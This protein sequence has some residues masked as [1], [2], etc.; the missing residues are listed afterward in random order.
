MRFTQLLAYVVLIAACG[1]ATPPP[2]PPPPADLA[3]TGVTLIDGGVAREGVTVL[4]DGEKI[5]AV[6]AAAELV[7]PA[8][9]RVVDG[10]GRFLIPGLWDVHVHLVNEPPI[11]PER[12]LALLLAH[13][14]VGVRDMGS[15]W[16][17]IE[18]LRARLAAG[19]IAGP[20]IV[21]PG[22]FVDGPQ[23]A[24][25]TVM[26]VAGAGE[27]RAAVRELR[28][29]GVDFIKAQANLPREAYQAL[30]DEAGQLGAEVHG[31]VP[32][33]LSALEVAAAGQVTIEHVSPS[34]PS[35]GALFFSCSA[36]ED[37][38]RLELA[39]IAAARAA[40]GAGRGQIAERDRAL[41]RAL[42]ES[43]DAEK[44]AALFAGLRDRGTRVV[45]TLVWSSTYSPYQAELPPDL[46]VEVM[47]EALREQWL[48]IWKGY[49]ERVG[50]Q[51]LEHNRRIADAAVT[52]VGALHAAGVK[53]LAGTD[54]PFGFVLPGFSLH[55]ELELLVAAGL[56]P[57]EALTAAT[58]GAAELLGQQGERGSVEAGQRADLVLLDADPL[59]DIR[60][61]REI[62][63]VVTGGAL[64]TREDLD[65]LVAD[66]SPVT[67]PTE[68]S[69][70][71]P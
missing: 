66:T 28:E 1:P 51:R 71:T 13:G 64:Y 20:T 69:G 2:E 54:S 27:A 38:L 22:P 33:A 43:Y 60:N 21:S 23:P 48:G 7:P 6:G 25:P 61:T 56:T 46:P 29:R 3:I 50:P 9:T 42:I 67:S 24:G 36:R 70:R 62:A 40:E 39:A 45:P 57:G 8:D 41:Q 34:L 14:V 49:F 37:E 65:R 32:D 59:A 16:A 31:H 35:D 26:P 58:R 47:P 12:Q 68:D 10:T 11:P 4:V 44:A 53:V 17:R 55:Q 52:L 15:D 19:E 5:S 18:A 63:A 30:V